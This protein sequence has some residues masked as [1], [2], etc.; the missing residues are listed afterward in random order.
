MEFISND[1]LFKYF[2]LEIS[3]SMT[4]QINKLTQEIKDVKE[5]A[6]KTINEELKDSI[7]HALTL[8]LKELKT[9]HSFE[10]N[11]INVENGHKLMKKRQELLENV[12]QEVFNKLLVF[13]TSSQYSDLM[14]SKIKE[15][16]N[17]F[18]KSYAIFK[19]KKA[20]DLL[21]KVIKENYNGKFE[22]QENFEIELGGFIASCSEMGIETDET[23]DYRLNDKKEWFY[24][25]SN[26]Y[27]K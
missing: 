25:N 24:E 16:N 13:S 11:K 18:L 20:D 5:Q 26:L 21:A 8:E 7:S 10:I 14:K 27:I 22:I 23:I 3:T 15:L 17:V 9:N 19:I 2:E 1:Q 4:K 6:L 12:F